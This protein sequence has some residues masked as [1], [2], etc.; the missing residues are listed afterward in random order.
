MIR[1]LP[2]FLASVVLSTT[3]IL[4]GLAM[5]QNR[6]TGTEPHDN[7]RMNAVNELGVI[8]VLMY[9]AFSTEPGPHD[10]WTRSLDDFR[11][12]LQWLHDRDFFVISVRQL[13]ENDIDVPLGKH[14]VVLTFDDASSRQFLFVEN[15]EGNLVPDPMSAVG[16][17]DDFFATHPD[18]GKSAHFAVV[19]GN[20]F[21]RSDDP[22]NSIDQCPAKLQYLVSNGYEV[23]NH[24][25]GH[26]NLNA[27]SSDA[28]LWEVAEGALF[29]DQHVSGPGNLSRVLTLPYGEPIVPGSAAEAAVY[30]GFDWNGTH[31]ALEG[32]IQVTGGPVYSPSST[33]WDPMQITR[34][35]TD[36]DS[37]AYWFGA[38]DRGELHLYTSDGDPET[39]T[40]PQP[41]PAFLTNEYDPGF[42]SSG[43]KTLVEYD[44][45]APVLAIG[46]GS[47]STSVTPSVSEIVPGTTVVVTE[48]NLRLRATASIQGH[49]L[50][51]LPL[52]AKL[53]VAAGPVDDDSYRWWNV[54]TDDG[55]SG[56]VVETYLTPAAATTGNEDT[57]EAEDDA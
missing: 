25:W 39:I 14:P 10:L 29:L 8:P 16:V 4:P 28:I 48:N 57:S 52:G 41:L 1:W 34:F 6:P 15:S 35:N 3:L 12:D 36:P 23:G 43:G 30:G 33:W 56:W 51:V 37:I 42:I 54:T 47:T 19:A 17:L 31:L 21:A 2:S 18:F 27:S 55:I 40:L 53:D 5:E 32:V 9:H 44:V 20:C 22:L 26:A 49:I 38:I 45:E 13:L 11:A 50:V 7:L 24:T 46:N